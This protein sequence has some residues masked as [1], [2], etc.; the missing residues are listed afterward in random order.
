M[1]VDASAILAIIQK[2]MGWEAFD[3]CL[4]ERR[5]PAFITPIN[6]WEVAARLLK[7]GVDLHM[8]TAFDVIES[9]RI[10]VAP[11][12]ETQAM[13]AMKAQYQFGKGR[14]PVALNMGDCFAY[15]LM[16]FREDRLLFKGDDFTK[17]DLEPAL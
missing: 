14:H 7:E 15:A 6:A 13:M 3:R 10:G 17:T 8:E 12:D 16:R 9:Y 2:E 4:K 5:E 11:T 1:V